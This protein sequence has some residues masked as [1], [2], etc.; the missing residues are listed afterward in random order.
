[1]NRRLIPDV[2]RAI[3]ESPLRIVIATHT[4]VGEGLAPPVLFIRKSKQWL[5]LAF[6]REKCG[7]CVA[8]DGRRLRVAVNY[9]SALRIRG[10]GGETPP[11]H[12]ALLFATMVKTNRPYALS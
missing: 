10:A 5:R 2:F 11:L 6:L 4:L 8:K 3:R 7:F 1:M 9:C 12:F